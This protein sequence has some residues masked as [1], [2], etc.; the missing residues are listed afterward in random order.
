MFQPTSQ[1]NVATLPGPTLSNNKMTIHSSHDNYYSSNNKNFNTEHQ[2]STTPVPKSITTATTFSDNNEIQFNNSTTNDIFIENRPTYGAYTNNTLPRGPYLQYKFNDTKSSNQYNDNNSS[3]DRQIEKLRKEFTGLPRLKMCKNGNEDGVSRARII[4]H[5]TI[6][7]SQTVH[8]YAK[9]YSN[10]NRMDN[11]NG[12]FNTHHITFP[13][14]VVTIEEQINENGFT[15]NKPRKLASTG[16][17]VSTYSHNTNPSLHTNFNSNNK[18]EHKLLHSEALN[19]NNKAHPLPNAT[20]NNNNSH[21]K[22]KH[23]PIKYSD[24]IKYNTI[25]NARGNKLTSSSSQTKSR[26]SLNNVV[27]HENI[28]GNRNG[29]IGNYY[30]QEL[31]QSNLNKAINPQSSSTNLSPFDSQSTLHHPNHLN[32]LTLHQQHQELPPNN[33]QNLIFCRRQNISS[34]CSSSINLCPKTINHHKHY[35]TLAD[36]MDIKING[37]N[38]DEGWAL[39]C[40]SVQALQDL[41][42]AGEFLFFSQFY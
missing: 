40:Q 27:D 10:E 7:C 29:I 13:D 21:M 11:T 20:T 31:V 33:A 25:S 39:L 15:H 41:F 19:V 42:L 16:L 22:F 3:K 6:N 5:E 12:Y 26:F 36:I 1:S 35:A 2:Y 14:N 18:I 28:I 17:V 34:A 37:L 4:G 32:A 8:R 23:N 9:N 24:N 38:Q 30:E